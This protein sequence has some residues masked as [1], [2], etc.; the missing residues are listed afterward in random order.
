MT[1]IHIP[2][3]KLTGSSKFKFYIQRLSTSEE[4]KALARTIQQDGL[5]NPLLVMKSDL[6]YIVLDGRKRLEAIFYLQ[7]LKKLPRTL[8]SVP[9][10]ISDQEPAD[11]E[12]E[13]LPFVPSEY[14]L[15]TMIMSA[16]HNG[17]DHKAI[18][19]R[20]QCSEKTIVQALCLERLDDK[21]KNLFSKGLLT[22]EQISAFATLPNKAS[23][24]RLLE[25]I[26][27]FASHK[28]IIEAISAGEAVLNLPNGETLI[29]PSRH[30]PAA[31]PKRY[32]ETE[33]EAA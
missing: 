9:C 21:I 16:Y 26:G 10:I 30:S 6:Q 24:W 23:Q 27:P 12:N 4:I 29:L 11:N 31:A 1:L 8:T 17:F 20:F 15:S 22:L 33:K 5:L 28:D 13:E 3:R 2:T 14:D 19:D 32:R 18:S 7:R 25:T